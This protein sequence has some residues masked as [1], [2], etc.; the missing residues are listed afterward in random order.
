[1]TPKI[2]QLASAAEPR[3]RFY[4][5]PLDNPAASECIGAH[6]PGYDRAQCDKPDADG[7]TQRGKHPISR[8]QA[9]ASNSPIKVG[10]WRKQ[11]YNLAVVCG[12]SRLVILDEDSY[13]ELARFCEDRGVQLP[14][15]YRVKTGKGFHYYF[16]V[17]GGV[18]ITNR[19]PF[20][21]DGYDIDVRGKGGYVVAEG[22]VHANGS[23]YEA[24]DPNA[25]IAVMPEWLIAYLSAPASSKVKGEQ[26]KAAETYTGPGEWNRGGLYERAAVNAIIAQLHALPQPWHQGASWDQGVYNAAC[27]L[28]EIANTPMFDLTIPEAEAIIRQHAPTDEVWGTEHVE[29]KIASAHSKIGSKPRQNLPIELVAE[30]AARKAANE[31]EMRNLIRNYRAVGYTQDAP[32]DRKV[33]RATRFAWNLREQGVTPTEASRSFRRISL[34]D[35]EFKVTEWAWEG[36]IPLGIMTGLAGWAG[37]GKSTVTAWAIAKLTRGEFEGDL[38]GQPVKVLIVAGEDDIERQLGPRLQ[39]AG[40]DMTMVEVFQP[41][42]TVANGQSIDTVMQIRDDLD[43]IRALLIET[44]AKVLILDPILSFVNGNPNSQGDVRQQLDPLAALARELNVAI[45]LVMHFKKGNGIAGEKVSGSHVWRD[46]L[47]SL[48]VMAVDEE[49]GYRVVSVDKSNYSDARGRSMLFEVRSAEVTGHDSRGNR[50]SQWVSQA[51]YAG[52]SAV[53]V[54]DVLEAESAKRDGRRVV[55]EDTAEIIGWICEQPEPV[56]WSAIARQAGVDPNA[57]EGPAKR[58]RTNLMRKLS[59]AVDRGDLGKY[60][61]GL[62]GKPTGVVPLPGMDDEEAY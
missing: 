4:Y 42:V 30:S 50:R 13:G 40:A 47:R 35:I 2:G 53:S 51:V 23:T 20:K 9:D 17:P 24:E 33:E 44:G 43:T 14:E 60:G 59:R 22:S 7:K 10:Y 52:Q 11:G 25:D 61:K 48:L 1:M 58:E 37:I 26:G 31:T 29:T 39:V 46:A 15:T 12:P 6:P 54:D 34:T 19:N 57:K 21:P 28:L 18:E 3:E 56:S 49:S 27:S 62:Y 8:W 16:R 55:N 41:T 38:R 32:S 36:M 45:I 5:A